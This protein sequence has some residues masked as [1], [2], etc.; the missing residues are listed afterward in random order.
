MNMNKVLRRGLAGGMALALMIGCTACSS[1]VVENTRLYFTNTG[2]VLSTL[3]SSGKGADK[4]P[5]SSGESSSS[6]E[7][8]ATPTDLKVDADGNYS[9]TGVDN[10]DYYLLYFC[11]PDATEDGD[12]FIYSSQPINS[13]SSNAYS[14]VCAEEFQY[15]FG[16]YLV[17]VFAFPKL[18]DSDHTM[19]SAATASYSYSG[20][21][22][23]PEINYFWNPFDGTMGVQVGNLDTYQFEVYPDQ[24]DITFTNVEDSSDVVTLTI[25]D[26]TTDNYAAQTSALTAGATYTLTASA[27]SSDSLVL[28]GTSEINTI[29]DSLTLGET[30]LYTPVYTYSD[31]FAN[32]IF[33]WP[34]GCAAFDLANGG[35]AGTGVAMRNY[36]I[37]VTPTATN[38][39]ASY[40]YELAI[41]ANWGDMTGT[42]DLKADG[43]FH[44]E[45]KGGGPVNASTIDGT[46]VDNGDGTATLS[47]DHSSIVIN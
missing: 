46:W 30:S 4:K 34:L 12:T 14:G 24:V 7:A 11:A 6:G 29:S 37:M 44:M 43:T 21:L 47:Y 5:T 27:T 16:S 26:V 40:S 35:S 22:S 10:A 41:P 31:G 32:N 25:E 33:N 20:D 3:F 36:D 19:S 23:A 15:G 9:F 2:T 45:N 8:L 1:T 42:F 28:N 17:K 18:T 13:N 39:G 38:A